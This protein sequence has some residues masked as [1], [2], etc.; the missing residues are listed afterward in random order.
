MDEHANKIDKSKELTRFNQLLEELQTEYA[1]LRETNQRLRQ[2][3]EQLRSENERLL[4]QAEDTAQLG[5]QGFS[6]H[7]RSMLKQQLRML[8]KRIDHHLKETA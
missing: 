6:E 8:I 3:N 1:R 4:D 7:E 5:E 2:E